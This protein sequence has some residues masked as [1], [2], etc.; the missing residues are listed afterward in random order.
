MKTLINHT[1]KDRLLPLSSHLSRLQF[2]NESCCCLEGLWPFCGK[3][4]SRTSDLGMS[5]QL[6][7]F[8][9]VLEELDICLIV[10]NSPLQ[11]EHFSGSQVGMVY[12]TGRTTSQQFEWSRPHALR[13]IGLWHPAKWEK[14][15]IITLSAVFV[16]IATM[17]ARMKL[18][19]RCRCRLLFCAKELFWY[20]YVGWA[21]PA[22]MVAETFM[23]T[24]TC[25]A[26][27]DSAAFGCIFRWV[28]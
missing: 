11:D 7:F 15:R 1:W 3:R 17:L 28:L 21:W 27:P 13:A 10:Y 22:N 9:D 8:S 26:T 4:V 16:W 19:F 5:S 2:Q 14:L 20:A 18:S 25:K 6:F 23:E 24:K 12:L